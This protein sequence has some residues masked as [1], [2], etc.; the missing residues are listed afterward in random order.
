M[1]AIGLDRS[2]AETAEDTLVKDEGNQTMVFN[3]P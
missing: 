1:A 3:V 2:R